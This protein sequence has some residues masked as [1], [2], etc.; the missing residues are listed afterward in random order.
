MEQRLGGM[1]IIIHQLTCEE[2]Q[3]LG[4]D[5]SPSVTRLIPTQTVIRLMGYS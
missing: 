3:L 5:V 4:T 1:L 2:N